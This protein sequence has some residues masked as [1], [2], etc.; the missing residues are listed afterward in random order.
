MSKPICIIPSS[1][2]GEVELGKLS[3]KERKEHP[4]AIGIFGGAIAYVDERYPTLLQFGDCVPYTLKK[5][6]MH[7]GKPS[8]QSLWQRIIWKLFGWRGKTCFLHSKNAL[9]AYEP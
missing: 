4:K 7:P 1:W 6:Y 5:G 8:K 2:V 3:R 9:E